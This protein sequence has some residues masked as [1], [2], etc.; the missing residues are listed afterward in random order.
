MTTKRWKI[1]KRVER[2]LDV[3]IPPAT[4]DHASGIQTHV[5]EGPITRRHAKKL[6]QEMHAFRA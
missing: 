3:D 6:Q 4:Q 5:Y 2:V 1:G